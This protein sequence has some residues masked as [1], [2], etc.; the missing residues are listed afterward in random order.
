M[1]KYENGGCVTFRELHVFQTSL[2]NTGDRSPARRNPRQNSRTPCIRGRIRTPYTP[3]PPKKE[4]FGHISNENKY[5]TPA[6]NSVPI[7]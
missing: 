3:P 4:K 6:V 2:L 5:T 1:N 7:L